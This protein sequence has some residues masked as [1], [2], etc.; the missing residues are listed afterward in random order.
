MIVQNGFDEDLDDFLAP[1]LILIRIEMGFKFFDLGYDL[2]QVIRCIS[3]E[4]R[5]WIVQRE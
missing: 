3:L 2:G 4:Q 5:S 1:F